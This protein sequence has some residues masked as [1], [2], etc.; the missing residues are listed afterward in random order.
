MNDV[1]VGY[2]TGVWYAHRGDRMIAT[3]TTIGRNDEEGA[4]RW[5]ASLLVGD[6]VLDYDEA[7]GRSAWGFRQPA[8]QEIAEMGGDY[9]AA[10]VDVAF[11]HAEDLTAL[12]A[13]E[14]AAVAVSALREAGLL[15]PPAPP[16]GGGED[17]TTAD[18]FTDD[19]G[20]I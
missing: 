17:W 3:N 14:L 19:T 1:S 11:R 18:E 20:D 13:H 5:A 2:D 4:R 10:V 8:Q 12:R 9:A 16:N 6:E 7:G 15:R